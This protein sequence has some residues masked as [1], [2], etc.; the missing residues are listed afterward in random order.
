MG[1][2]RIKLTK[3]N[4]AKSFLLHRI[5]AETFIPNPENKKYKDY[6]FK[7]LDII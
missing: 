4:V 7:I 5:V 6:E 3:N 1:Y 2:V